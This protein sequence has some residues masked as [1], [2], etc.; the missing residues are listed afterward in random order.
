MK[1]INKKGLWFYGLSGSGKSYA[2]KIATK[3]KK[4]SFLIDGDYVRKFISEDLGYTLRDRKIQIRRILGIVR[5]S[6]KSNL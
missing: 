5:I 4:K 6:L 1:T 3:R 2:S